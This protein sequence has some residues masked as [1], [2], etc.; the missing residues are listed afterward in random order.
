MA[1]DGARVAPPRTAG[2]PDRLVL[3]E[4][5]AMVVVRETG[6]WVR[7]FHPAAQPAARLVCFP[8]AG[9]SASYLY[10]LSRAMG[11]EVDVVCLQY[12]GRQDR[13][14]EP[15][16]DTVAAFADR[17]ATA[18][19]PWTGGRLILFGHGLG[20]TIAYETARRLE[21]AG[22]AVT[23]LIVSG[24]RGPTTFRDERMHQLDD[25]QLLAEA[26]CLSELG[27][28]LLDDDL[29]RTVLPALRA[30]YHAA[31]TY[32]HTPGEPLRCPVT[33]LVVD[34]DLAVTVAEAKDWEAH[35]TGPFRLT[36]FTGDH[37]SLPD[38]LR[39]VVTTVRAHVAS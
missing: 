30:G 32:R 8:P 25:D 23:A 31:E 13:S 35:T 18:L 2:G 24:R 28:V 37:F 7:R 11:P 33:A 15:C 9:G 14:G 3:A 27:D 12:P 34:A 36:V 4:G 38:R 39:E 21:A 17:I 10:P 29:A 6:V 19:E 16:L 26:R 1:I 22:V 5:T 20:A